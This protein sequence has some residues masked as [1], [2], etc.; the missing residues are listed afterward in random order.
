MLKLCG[1]SQ[2]IFSPEQIRGSDCEAE[3]RPNRSSS[4]EVLPFL[5]CLNNF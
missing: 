1:M 5:K 3:G 4:A 2:W